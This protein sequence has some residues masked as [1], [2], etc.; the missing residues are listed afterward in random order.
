MCKAADKDNHDIGI[1]IPSENIEVAISMNV[2]HWPKYLIN[3]IEWFLFQ[4]ILGHAD[5]HAKGRN[6]LFCSLLKA[7]HIF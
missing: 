7:F 5:F 3:E 1:Y 6:I 2:D 4:I